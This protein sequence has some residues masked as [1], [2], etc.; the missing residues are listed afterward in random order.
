M[1]PE[2]T[3]NSG[4]AD[5]PADISTLTE[6]AYAKLRVDLLSG[7]LPPE[8]KLRL[9]DLTSRYGIKPS[10]LREALAR[11]AS[12]RLVNFEPQRGFFVAPVSLEEL[13]DLCN[14]RIDLAG[15]A[16]RAS[17]AR[18]DDAWEAEILASMHLLERGI[19]PTAAESQAVFDEWEL[20]HDRFH[21]SLLAACG[22]P[23]LLRF[24]GIL[25]DQYRRYRCLVVAYKAES[26]RLWTQVRTH[27]RVI[28]DTVLARKDDLAVELLTKHIEGSRKQV[29]QLFR[30]AGMAEKRKPST[31]TES[32]PSRSGTRKRR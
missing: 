23:W 25:S 15:K 13:N 27:H 8:A 6:E 32:L 14:L 22:S 4:I 17:I 30:R 28:A 3:E 21:R 26:E 31:K 29:V 19:R 1:F 16:L 5:V 20:R 12:E 7:R 24:C 18:G 10:P 2:Q 9:K 11:L